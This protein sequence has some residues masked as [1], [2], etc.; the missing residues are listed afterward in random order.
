MPYRL[1]LLASLLLGSMVTAAD[2]PT[3][4]GPNRDGISAET[5]LLK[6]WPEGGPKQLWTAK[7]L[8]LGWGTP[9]F[10]GGVI[11]GTGAREGKDGV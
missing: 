7:N 6:S 2:W 3:F 1:A 10:S 9:S 5:G 4:R 8:G 11:Y